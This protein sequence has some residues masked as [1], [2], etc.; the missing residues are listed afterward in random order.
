MEKEDASSVVGLFCR[1]KS[2]EELSFETKAI[3]PVIFLKEAESR[4]LGRHRRQEV[5]ISLCQA[6]IYL[7]NERLL[8]LVLHQIQAS[9]LAEPKI[10]RVS[11]FSGVTGD[12]F[13]IPL[14]VIRQVETRPLKPVQS[15]EMRKF[16]ELI[17]PKTKQLVEF[18]D[19]PAIE[20][21]YDE[22]A[23]IGRYKDYI[24]SLPRMGVLT[25]MFTKIHLVYDKLIILGDE[26]VSIM[27]SLKATVS[28]SRHRPPSRSS[29]ASELTYHP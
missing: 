27:P 28:R 6:N 14:C 11:R 16:F 10:T 9:I 3:T 20:L 15:K 24:E 13:E 8:L 19:A 7:T 4:M 26:I 23:A 5:P 25:R 22:Q 2:T 12:W 17:F 1:L 29:V 21:I 18:L